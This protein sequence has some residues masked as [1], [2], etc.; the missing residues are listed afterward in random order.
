MITDFKNRFQHGDF[1]LESTP[2]YHTGGLLGHA[3]VEALKTMCSEVGPH[4]A[5][6]DHVFND[7]LFIYFPRTFAELEKIMPKRLSWDGLAQA[8]SVG[9]AQPTLPAIVEVPNAQGIEIDALHYSRRGPVQTVRAMVN[10]EWVT[11]GS[12]VDGRFTPINKGRRMWH[13]V[14]GFVKNPVVQRIASPALVVLHA[15]T[16]VYGQ[17]QQ[18]A[19][20]PSAFGHGVVN[21]GLEM[22]GYGVIYTGLA[23]IS[24]PLSLGAG[25]ANI[26]ANF[27]PDYDTSPIRYG[28]INTYSGFVKGL[29]AESWM[30]GISC[31]RTIGTSPS[32]LVDWSRDQF[33]AHLPQVSHNA[34][35][36][37]RRAFLD[38]ENQKIARQRRRQFTV[39]WINRVV[40][41]T[42]PHDLSQNP[43]RTPAQI[44]QQAQE[45]QGRNDWVRQYV[46]EQRLPHHTRPQIIQQAEI[47]YDLRA[48]GFQVSLSARPRRP[49]EDTDEE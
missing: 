45:E 34:S 25:A 12:M 9:G 13:K 48:R 1:H 26:V 20:W 36:A 17:W 6:I 16:N 37:I 4:M 5:Q 2:L 38:A 22:G 32:R 44:R 41:R 29:M 18:G 33:N 8:A 14:T 39:N 43:L 47:E 7:P 24:V 28:P 21:T 15:G 46:P 10:G 42:P 19:D 35:L 30:S 11:I 23:L 3:Y 27:L 40:G 49:S 31:A